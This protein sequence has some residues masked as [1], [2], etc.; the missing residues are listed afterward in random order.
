MTKVEAAHIAYAGV[1]ARFGISSKNRWSQKDGS[2]DYRIFFYVL[3]QEIE[4]CHDTEWV[5]S[6]LDHYNLILFKDVNGRQEGLK[7]DDES[8]DEGSDDPDGSKFLAALRAQATA[9]SAAAEKTQN[10]KQPDPPVTP[11][12]SSPGQGGPATIVSTQPEGGHANI[13][14]ALATRLRRQDADESSDLSEPEEEH[15][16]HP[17]TSKPAETSTTSAKRKITAITGGSEDASKDAPKAK[18]AR[19]SHGKGKGKARVVASDDESA[20]ETSKAKKKQGKSRKRGK[21]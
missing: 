21:N 10:N 13:I 12:P 7:S 17:S 20:I 1:L 3:L 2:F 15:E 5:T 18:A 6:L 14:P 8:A 11:P 16:N 4:K 19:R 9:R